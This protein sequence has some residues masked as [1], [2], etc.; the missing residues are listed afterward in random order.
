[1]MKA[2]TLVGSRPRNQRSENQHLENWNA[3]AAQ[4]K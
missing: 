2:W 4:S 3:M 1:M